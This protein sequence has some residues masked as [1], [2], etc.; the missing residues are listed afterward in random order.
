MHEE[1]RLAGLADPLFHQ[2]AGSVVVT[3]RTS[4]VD[5]ELESRLPSPRTSPGP[6]HP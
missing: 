6:H 1:M 5:R 4:R 2:T 3:L